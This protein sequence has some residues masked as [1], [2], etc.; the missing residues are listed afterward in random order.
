MDQNFNIPVVL[1]LEK[2][3]CYKHLLLMLIDTVESLA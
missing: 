1:L 3:L 2:K